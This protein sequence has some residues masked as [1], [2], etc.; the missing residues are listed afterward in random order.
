[1]D[2]VK[3]ALAWLK[4]YHFWVLCVV[5][6]L[7]AWSTWAS[8]MSDVDERFGK[9]KGDLEG[10]FS[11]VQSVRRLPNHPNDGVI[12]ALHNKIDR[13]DEKGLKQTVLQA[14]T[15]LY[16]EQKQ[17]NRLPNV[18]N[19]QF[20]SDFDAHKQEGRMTELPDRDRE[21]YQNEIKNTSAPCSTTSACAGL[22]RTKRLPRRE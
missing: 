21:Q 13:G 22:S 14:W 9:R 17:K 1:M 11:S 8:A 5:V 20:E 16:N 12:K 6:L 18:L 19:K 3:L 4:K 7:T 2:K 10:K 15:A